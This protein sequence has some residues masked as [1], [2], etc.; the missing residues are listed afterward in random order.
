MTVCGCSSKVVS[1][2]CT[3]NWGRSRR[4]WSCKR[5]L[6]MSY[7]VRSKSAKPSLMPNSSRY[8][9]KSGEPMS[10]AIRSS[11]N[12]SGTARSNERCYVRRKISRRKSEPCIE[13]DHRKDQMMTVCKVALANLA[14]WLRDRYF[15]A[16]Y[17]HA[18]WRR[19]APFFQLAGKVVPAISTV[20]VELRPCNDRALNRDLA[21]LCERVNHASLRLSDGR[22]LAFTISPSR[23]IL[24]AQEYR[25]T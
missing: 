7:G 21:V 15:P 9:S 4:R 3:G 18:T 24:P 11:A 16:S 5:W 23:C 10:C 19:L 12:R 2:S 13:L 20:Q 8:E 6:I 17:A 22:Q 14:M 25:V 1:M